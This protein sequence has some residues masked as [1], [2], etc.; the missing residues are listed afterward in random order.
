M[1]T[2]TQ[3]DRKKLKI[4]KSTLWYRQKAIKVEKGLK[5]TYQIWKKTKIV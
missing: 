4:N 5:Y 2:I 1:M 3:E